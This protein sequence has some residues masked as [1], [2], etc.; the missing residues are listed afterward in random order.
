MTTKIAGAILRAMT[1]KQAVKKLGGPSKAA[2]KS[3]I[4]RTNIN[5]WL[6]AKNLPRWRE[7]DIAKIIDLA[8]AA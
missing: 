7:A 8:K 5:Y 4:G 6:K 3:G 2:A 1:L